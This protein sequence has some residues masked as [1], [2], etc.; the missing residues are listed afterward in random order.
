[1]ELFISSNDNKILLRSFAKFKLNLIR[2][3]NFKILKY[4]LITYL[5]LVPII[6]SFWY[7]ILF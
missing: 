6:Q 3:T 7:Y 1:M 2:I 5:F 4:L